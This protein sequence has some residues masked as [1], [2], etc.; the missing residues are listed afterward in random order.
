[1]TPTTV[2]NRAMTPL[3]WG[4]LI[5]LSV[6]WGGSFF[7]V[8]VAVKELP[9]LTIVVTRV[10]LAA[11]ALAVVL[12]VTGTRLP[13]TRAAWSAFMVMGFFNNAVPFTLIVWGQHH[14]ASGVASIFN[15]ATPLFTVMVAHAATDDEKATAGRLFGVIVGLLGVAVMIGDTAWQTFGVAI[16]AQ[17]AMLVAALSYAFG[18]V[19]GRRFR[20]MGIDPLATAP[21]QVTASSLMLMPIML[22]VER[23]WTLPV[24]SL[25]TAAALVALALAS[26]A[27]AYII[28]FRILA[29]AGATNLLLVTFLIPVS[30]ILLGVFLL[31]ETLA[32]A[33]LAGMA[34][35]GVGLAAVDGRP[36]RWLRGL[37][38]RL[39][40]QAR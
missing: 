17:I 20:T 38:G 25:A 1:M 24:P 18:G 15:A 34:L 4:L 26:T 3:E 33:H 12:R 13:R 31:G 19:Y 30:A 27:F 28:Y 22:I 6:L 39:P 21:G 8:G 23:P 32:G 36:W 14:V 16:L 5:L 29:T 10:V 11:I 37:A 40:A 9:P 35:I 7:F 2:V